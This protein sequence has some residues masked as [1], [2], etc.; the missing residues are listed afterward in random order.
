[1]V[2]LRPTPT[3][4]NYRRDMDRLYL[5][6]QQWNYLVEH[7]D[8]S[9]GDLAALRRALDCEVKVKNIEIV[10]SLTILEEVIGTQRER[11]EKCRGLVDIL[12]TCVGHRWLKPLN[13]R[14]VAEA[15]ADGLLTDTQRYLPRD[16]RRKLRALAN[17]RS[18]LGAVADDTHAQTDLFKK[19]Q[20][21]LRPRADCSRDGQD[22]HAQ[23]ASGV[24]AGP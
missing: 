5:D 18:D 4:I 20:D 21:R 17:A 14:Y 2:S 9:D 8:Y 16:T 24:V 6:T 3:V 10:T 13:E 15:N 1:M 22:G 19:D 12:F 11:P 7:P 23:R